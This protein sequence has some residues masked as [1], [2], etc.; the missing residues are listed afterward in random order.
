MI[1]LILNAVATRPLAP[2]W[3][4]LERGLASLMLGVLSL[5]LAAC[6]G[7]AHM[8]EGQQ[9][10]DQGRAEEGLSKLEMAVAADPHSG[11]FRRSLIMARERVARDMLG[12]ADRLME[13]GRFEE[14]RALYARIQSMMPTLDRARQGVQMAERRVSSQARL[15]EAAKA[16]DDKDWP[17]AANALQAVLLDD[18]ANER[19]LQLKRQMS[20]LT[21]PPKQGQGLS[22]AYKKS[23]SIEFKEVPLK[24]AFEV[25]ARTSGLNFVF[26]KDVKT[27]AKT[28]IFLRNSTVE[29]VLYFLL[30]SHQ[31][32]QQVMNGNTLLI[33]PNNPAKAKDY[34]ELSVRSF[35]MVNADAKSVAATIK[36]LFKG[37]DVVVDDKLNMLVVRDTPETIRL[38]E[39]VVALHDV[40]EP[41]VML[42]VEI[43]EVGRNKL[44]ELGVRWP[45]SASFTPLSSDSGGSL[46]INDLRRL[47]RDTV[48]VTVGNL[49]VNARKEDTDVNI[50]AN[51]RIR[52]INR[53][54]AKILIGDKLPLITSSVTSTGVTSESIS[55]QDVGLKLEVEPTIYRGN[56]IVIK[57]GLEV[58]SIAGT[59]VSKQGTTAYTIGTRTA[60]TALRLRDGENQILAGLIND[61]DRRTSNKVPGL[62]DL[63]VAGRLFGSALDEG[64]KTEVI[65]S[66]TPR[67]VRNIPR[68]EWAVQ[69]FKSGTEN[70]TRIKPAMESAP[71]VM[72]KPVGLPSAQAVP[73][74]TSPVPS[75]P[76]VVVA[77]KSTE[78]QSDEDDAWSQV[79]DGPP[80]QISMSWSGPETVQAGRE[81]T[82]VLSVNASGSVQAMPVT[83]DFDPTQLEVVRVE[84]GGWLGGEGSKVPFRSNLSGGR[85]SLSGSASPG[86]AS[87][88]GNLA[89]ITFKGLSSGVAAKVAVIKAAPTGRRGVSAQ[90]SLPKPYQ[91]WLK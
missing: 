15:G 67:L 20:D 46:T 86:G 41:E 59:Q 66:I 69:E 5:A 3:R 45:D 43:L 68:S 64:K 11:E 85:L 25:I 37:R 58:S 32:E 31:L 76:V 44:M 12:Q 4:Q 52:V 57:V 74:V 35:Q 55:Y 81:F 54:K 84:S 40:P 88:G 28:S 48:G 90:I 73:P 80:G 53:E 8:R 47:N 78:S 36:T 50:L 61:E 65:L 63:P 6:T 60:N 33:Y 7:M 89:R 21:E 19:A 82:V 83:L 49:K 26:D 27:D 72:D 30:L 16:L 2:R 38:I 62:G 71:A 1:G 51:P 91:V 14:A 9:L 13:A 77:G 87:G 75:A 42:E 79:D 24:Q 56:D 70:S 10:L 22:D 18:P 29:S 39:K 17:M 23:I 34:Q